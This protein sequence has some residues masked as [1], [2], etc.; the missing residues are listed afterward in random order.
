MISHD[1]NNGIPWLFTLDGMTINK[2]G[3]FGPCILWEVEIQGGGLVKKG[4]DI[5]LYFM[6][7]LKT[8]LLQSS[9][10]A[11]CIVAN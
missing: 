9:F 6:F 8:Y 7:E 3:A 11:L 5:F 10:L 4:Y 1:F 2:E